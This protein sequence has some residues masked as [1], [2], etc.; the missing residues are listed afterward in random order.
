MSFIQNF[1][2]KE[3]SQ[4]IKESYS[5]NEALYK[6]GVSKNSGSNKSLLRDFIKENNINIEHFNKSNQ[7]LD[8]FTN[9][10]FCT[11]NSL[12]RYFYRKTKDNYVCAICG[13]KPFWNEKPLTLR[14]DHID[15][16][17]TNNSIGNLRWVCPNCDR[18]LSTFGYKNRRTSK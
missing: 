11:Q 14:I 3:I 8:V 2:K 13:Q 5:L 7:P 15:G 17:C 1:T 9:P 6:L 16:N 10:S 18:Q 12:R 4:V